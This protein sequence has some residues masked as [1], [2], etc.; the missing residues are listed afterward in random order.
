MLEKKERIMELDIFRSLAI[1]AVIFIHATSTTLAKTLGTSSY[2][3]F[4]FINI[5]SKFAVPVFIFLSGFVLFYNYLDKP[6]NKSMLKSFYTKRL[7]YILVPYIFFSLFYFLLNCYVKGK[8]GLPF[9][10]L[11]HDFGLQLLKGTAH[12][13]LYYVI[14][15]LQLYIVFPLFLWWFQKQR[16]ILPWVAIIG[17]AIQWLF[18]YL[19]KYGFHLPE[20]GVYRTGIRLPLP[21]GSVAFS[22]MS[23]YL[24]GAF[25]AAY[26]SR[27]KEWLIVTREG[28][29]SGKGIVWLFVW[30]AWLAAGIIHVNLYYGLNTRGSKINS[31]WY[32]LM[33]DV[34]SLL[35]CIV[36]MQVSYMIY[37]YGWKW[38][39]T[40]LTSMG[41]CSFGI[42][43]LHPAVLFLYRKIPVHGGSVEYALR[44]GG[45]W[46]VSLG[47]SWIV[48]YIA[49]RY[50]PWSWVFFGTA[51]KRPQTNMK[52][53]TV[54]LNM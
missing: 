9:T 17:L 16:S 42:F 29:K 3:P 50:I 14:I 13:H 31:L 24:F 46:I 47:V 35:S 15:M 20:A 11:A 7:L 54:K 51:P 44:I 1:M 4:L 37:R 10:Q 30:A 6:L 33:W 21:K 40:A 48:V 41:A 45:G 12:T 26:Y 49:F 8:L 38:L 19:Y 23:F 53:K 39:S 2:Y 18:V 25:I 36:L 22:Y 43:L 52:D 5:F 34:H 28:F 27:L 32:E